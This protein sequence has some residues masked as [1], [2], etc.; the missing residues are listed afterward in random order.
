MVIFNLRDV[1]TNFSIRMEVDED[2]QVCE[3]HETAMEYW[4]EDRVLLTKDYRILRDD[5]RIGDIIFD[6]D[7]VEAMIDPRTVGKESLSR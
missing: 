5:E 4:G 3:L 1:V 7:T 6:G 2:E